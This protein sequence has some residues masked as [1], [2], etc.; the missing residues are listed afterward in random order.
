M[1][2]VVSFHRDWSNYSQDNRGKEFGM[3]VVV[4]P[5]D[6]CDTPGEIS[7]YIREH[8]AKNLRTSQES[9]TVLNFWQGFS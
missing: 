1:T 2:Y 9:I 6:T 3:A 5:V 8:L 7:L 4:I